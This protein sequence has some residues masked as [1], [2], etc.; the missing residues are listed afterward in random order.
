MGQCD[1]VCVDLGKDLLNCGYCGNGCVAGQQCVNGDCKYPCPKDQSDCGASCANLQND[2]LN[3]GMCGHACEAGAVCGNGACMQVC[4]AG[5][6]A[7]NGACVD[8]TAD[9]SNC[10]SCG[11]TCGASEQCVVGVCQPQCAAGQVLCGGACADPQTDPQNCGACGIA[12]GASE[13]CQSGKCKIS[14]TAPQALCGDA[15]VDVGSNNQNCGG[16]GVACAAG[17]VCTTG[18][19]VPSCDAGQTLCG[20]TCVSLPSDPQNCGACGK[21]CPQ[22][23]VCGGGQCALL[24]PAGQVACGDLCVDTQSDDKN[25]GACGKACAAGQACS[26]GTCA[27]TCKAQLLG[28]PLSDQWGFSWD[29]NERTT[30]SYDQAAAACGAIGGR[31]PTATE[32]HRVSAARTSQVGQLANV[33]PLWTQV[34]YATGDQ[35]Q[36]KL[37]DGSVSHQ[38][39]TKPSVY[40]CVCA[41]PEPAGFSGADCVGASGPQCST[42]DFDGQTH[43]IDSFDRARLDAGGAAWECARSGG[44]LADTGTLIAAIR[45]GLPNGAAAPHWTADQSSN[46]AAMTISWAASDPNWTAAAATVGS[47]ALSTMGTNTFRCVGPATELATSPSAPATATVAARTHLAYDAADRAAQK[48]VA[49]SDTC[50]FFGG[51]LASPVELLEGIHQ[52][53]AGGSGV[54]LWTSDQTGYNG[55]QFLAGTLKW[56]GSAPQLGWYGGTAA[57]W[58]YK[59]ANPGNPFRCDYFPVDAGYAGPQAAQCNGACFKVPA[60]FGAPATAPSMWLDAL[61]R[62]AQ[63]VA[64]AVSDCQKNGGR[65]PRER[66]YIE[67]IRGGLPNGSTA[68]V[69]TSDFSVNTASGARLVQVVRWS[70]QEPAF[71]DQY[72]KYMTWSNLP[73][74][75]PYRCLWT[76][77]AR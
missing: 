2:A 14:C 56:T 43:N 70:Q 41:P 65:L 68:F 54:P 57:G 76:N 33:N 61:D 26:G 12:C 45:A 60:P 59:N 10:G 20:K 44:H 53:L 63:P 40:R 24:C 3:C 34:P 29:G 6:V 51:H 64:A 39:A 19:C 50:V 73:D 67:A 74:P 58:A 32:I 1:G 66:D 25:C 75:R 77:E 16:C 69:F 48:W 7:C 9:P 31:L 8:L 55:T 46:Q 27:L 30:A 22:G 36:A 49:A 52:G 13:I 4:P 35:V 5:S 47:A 18:A 15:C 11:A 38:L 42:I 71:D 23:Q 28:N 37:S 21:T 62:P 72:N 17:E